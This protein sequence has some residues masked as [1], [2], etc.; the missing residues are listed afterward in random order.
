VLCK[1]PNSN[2]CSKL[3]S[4]DWTPLGWAYLLA[5]VNHGLYMLKDDVRK[6]YSTV[7]V[8]TS[9]NDVEWNE[10]N[11]LGARMERAETDTRH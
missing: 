7:Y 2:S 6:A 9:K 5:F 3:Y 11:P 4:V 8:I 1:A 10:Q